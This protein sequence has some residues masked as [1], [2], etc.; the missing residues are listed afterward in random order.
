MLWCYPYLQSAGAIHW[1]SALCIFTGC[2]GN[3]PTALY[4]P[5]ASGALYSQLAIERYSLL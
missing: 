3:M 5:R 1:L 4:L 2:M